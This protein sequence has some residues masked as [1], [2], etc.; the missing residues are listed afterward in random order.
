MKVSPGGSLD[1]KDIKGHDPLMQ[2]EAIAHGPRPFQGPWTWSESLLETL[3]HSP[4]LCQRSSDMVQGSWTQSEVL[5]EALSKGLRDHPR[6]YLRLQ[7]WSDDLSKA[8]L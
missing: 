3:G 4:R 6:P 7:E 8:P 1:A 5:P 2:S